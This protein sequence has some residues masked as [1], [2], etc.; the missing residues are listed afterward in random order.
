MKFV[1]GQDIFQRKAGFITSAI[2]FRHRT[3]EIF[4]MEKQISDEYAFFNF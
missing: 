3:V 2:I 1:P 4:K